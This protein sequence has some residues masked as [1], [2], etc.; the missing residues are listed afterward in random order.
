M[1]YHRSHAVAQAKRTLLL[2]L[3]VFVWGYA[4]QKQATEMERAVEEFKRRM[5]CSLHD[6]LLL[7]W[8]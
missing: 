3:G 4:H 7:L 2:T 1:P 5:L 8:L 6:F